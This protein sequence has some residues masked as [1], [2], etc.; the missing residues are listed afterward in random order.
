MQKNKRSETE[1]ATSRCSWAKAL[2]GDRRSLWTMTPMTETRERERAAEAERAAAAME[3]Y[4][5]ARQAMEQYAASQ[6]SQQTPPEEH[7]DEAIEG[8]SAPRTLTEHEMAIYIRIVNS[9]VMALAMSVNQP[10]PLL[11]AS[12]Y[13]GYRPTM[14]GP[15]NR[16]LLT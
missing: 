6:P 10:D 4:R 13:H 14:S 5:Y 16:F 11:G 15:Y 8:V 1:S 12:P 7:V 3:Q 2:D 9:E